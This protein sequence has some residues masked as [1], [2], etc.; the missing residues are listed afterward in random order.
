MR[1]SYD[2][3]MKK[4]LITLISIIILIGTS[5]YFFIF[6]GK[7]GS[8]ISYELTENISEIPTYT[9]Q[10]ATTER[11]NAHNAEIYNAAMRDQNATTC[12]GITDMKQKNECHDMIKV[13]IWKK[14]SDIGSCDTLS[15]I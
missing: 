15:S 10:Q 11:N 13:A 5:V 1:L 7:S 9:E 4:I 6:Q 14:D 3:Y 2:I 12:D 8:N